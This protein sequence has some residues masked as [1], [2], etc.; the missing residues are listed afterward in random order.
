MDIWAWEIPFQYIK[1][2]T[3]KK[4]IVIVSYNYY[5]FKWKGSVYTKMR[6]RLG[7]VFV[8]KLSN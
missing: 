6:F 7:F 3:G 8:I 5:L 2:N 1:E 4:Y